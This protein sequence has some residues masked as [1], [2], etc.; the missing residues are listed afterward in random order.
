MAAALDS[1]YCR[2]IDPCRRPH[3]SFSPWYVLGICGC[4]LVRGCEE[5]LSV[6]GVAATDC[7]SSCASPLVADRSASLFSVPF[8]H[9]GCRWCRCTAFRA[10]WVFGSFRPW[11]VWT[12]A[13]LLFMFWSTMSQPTHLHKNRKKRGHVSA[14]HGRVGKHR[15]HPA[16]RGNA[17]GLHHHRILFDKFHPGY[18]GKVGMRHFHKTDQK[19]FCPTVNLDRCVQSAGAIVGALCLSKQAWAPEFV[20]T[21]D[22]LVLVCLIV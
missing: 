10:A 1:N 15:K 16:G 22:G 6:P 2:C 19:Y 12:S 5:W 4:E 3:R 18:F 21:C 13:C 17:G 14:G 11:P 20:A 7:G 9:T 8:V